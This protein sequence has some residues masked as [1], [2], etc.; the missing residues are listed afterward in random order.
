MEQDEQKK[1][2]WAIGISIGVHGSLL[3]L[4]LLILAWK[5][6]NPPIPEYGIE[7]NFGL[8]N[9]GSGD[10][11]PQSNENVTSEEQ[12][13]SNDAET[14]DTEQNTEVETSTD[15][16]EIQT[17]EQTN[18]VNQNES[19]DVTEQVEQETQNNS[20]TS[21]NQ[22]SSS[23][24]SESTTENNNQNN[25]PK[26][27]VDNTDQSNQSNSDGNTE[28]TTGD[29][30]SETGTIDSQALMGE[31]GSSNGAQLEMSGWKWDFLPQ[32]DDDSEESGKIVFQITVNSEGYIEKIVVEQTTVTPA[33]LKKYREAVEE[34]TFSKNSSY[35]PAPYSTGKITFIIKSN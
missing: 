35:K 28:N 5:E 17:E 1:R 3:L 12:Q 25:Q 23:N 24:T 4:F 15:T 31:S 6:P 32:P 29:Q 9:V 13:E 16:E 21:D 10:T 27:S 11:Q 8:E 34:L 18:V 20:A 26:E 22:Q 19:P 30:G 2:K 7:L 14:N 33:V